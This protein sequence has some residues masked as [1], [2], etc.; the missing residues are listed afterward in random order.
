MKKARNL[1]ASYESSGR[2]EIPRLALLVGIDKY[3]HVSDLS[4]C[5][6][7]AMAMSELLQRNDD[8]S[9]NYDCEAL[10]SSGEEKITR[11]VLR[12]HW[13]RLFGV[14][15]G[16]ILFYFSGHGT[17]LKSG[18]YLVT[19]EG[20]QDDPGL[21]MDELLVL[22]NLSEAS[23]V[24]LIL[25]C[26]NAGHLGLPAA[27]QANGTGQY[28]AHLR[29]GLTIL[30]AS[31]PTEDAFEAEGQ[32]VFTRLV[33]GALSGGAADVR[34]LV[35]AASIY[36]YV[37][38]ALGPWEQRPMYKSHADQLPPVR[39]CRPAVSDPVLRELPTLFK[40]PECLL[41]LDPS[42]EFTH[43]SK[44]RKNVSLFKKFKM[45]RNAGL[46]TTVDQDD[47]FFAAMKC[48]RIGLT[49]VG[50]FY[51]RLAAEGRI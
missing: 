28:Q 41:R 51:W 3:D 31:R 39:T 13:N 30:A 32:G 16:D 36:G 22:A 34:G 18:G 19:Q 2:K 6:A 10:I 11:K 43:P 37:E 20:D 48:G 15:K 7:D 4:C 1:R 24:L 25:D 44:K 8:G 29:E 46:L 17:P 26:C 27:L 33:L 35:S 9:P 47:L 49:P 50:Q 45:L 12:S 42:Y 5:V 38:Q 21:A 23:S 40:A 14:Y